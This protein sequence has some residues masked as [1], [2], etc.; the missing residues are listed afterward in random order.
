MAEAA[1]KDSEIVQ[2]ARAQHA[3]ELGEG[4]EADQKEEI[5]RLLKGRVAELQAQIKSLEEKVATLEAAASQSP[6][7]DA[8]KAPK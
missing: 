2:A 1:A 5:D 8:K 3:K 4:Q 6:A 7:A